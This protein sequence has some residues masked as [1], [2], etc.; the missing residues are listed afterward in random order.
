MTSEL[1]IKRGWISCDEPNSLQWITATCLWRKSR[2]AFKG[3]S[4]D[5]GELT[6]ICQL[7]LLSAIQVAGMVADLWPV[8]K[9]CRDHPKE[10]LLQLNMFLNQHECIK[11]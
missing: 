1:N 10:A 2:K 11:I 7:C 9:D 6:K 5:Q 8:K 4:R 3:F